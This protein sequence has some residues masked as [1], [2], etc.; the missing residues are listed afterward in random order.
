M[1]SDLG[2]SIL[3]SK[4]DACTWSIFATNNSCQAFSTIKPVGL[5]RGKTSARV[6]TWNPY[7]WAQS[8]WNTALAGNSFAT[9]HSNAHTMTAYERVPLHF[10]ARVTLGGRVLGAT[11][12]PVV[13]VALGPGWSGAD[14]SRPWKKLLQNRC[15]QE[16]KSPPAEESASSHCVQERNRTLATTSSARRFVSNSRIPCAEGTSSSERNVV[17]RAGDSE[18]DPNCGLSQTW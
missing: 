18:T 14:I 2:F 15:V 1:Q 13:A 3:C 16:T 17:K 7:P 12:A 4:K 11:A 8:W 9:L 5:D 10:T 6:M